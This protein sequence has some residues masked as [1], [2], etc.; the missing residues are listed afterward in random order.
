MTVD[1]EVQDIRIFRAKLCERVDPRIYAKAK[2]KKTYKA[3]PGKLE[4]SDE[5]P[6]RVQGETYYP[7]GYDC[8]RRNFGY[9][10]I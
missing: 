7:S 10:N 5:K 1:E 6:E 9:Q 8:R 4:D 3:Q 2:L